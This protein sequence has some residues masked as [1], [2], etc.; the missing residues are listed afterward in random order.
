MI[1]SWPFLYAAGTSSHFSKDGV[2]KICNAG[3]ECAEQATYYPFLSQ[4]CIGQGWR[5][6]YDWFFAP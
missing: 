3:V 1:S 6:A 5:M 4:S 2:V